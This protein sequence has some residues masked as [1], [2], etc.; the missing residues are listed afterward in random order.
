MLAWPSLGGCDFLEDP[1][2]DA[3]DADTAWLPDPDALIALGPAVRDD[4]DPFSLWSIPGP[5]SLVHDGKRLLIRTRLG[6]RVVRLA[7]SLSLGDG[8]AFAYA[9]PPGRGRSA[10]AARAAAAELTDMLAGV[11]PTTRAAALTRTMVV[12]MRA[13][14]ALDAERAGAS[15]REIGQELF[16][17]A[18]QG[19]DWNDSAERAQVRYLLRQGRSMRDGGYRHLLHQASGTRS[20][21]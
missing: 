9:V 4:G 18:D 6:R 10:K 21:L 19:G 13:L 8:G 12:H 5:K 1:R 20:S 17:S 16:G 15:E 3:R 7:V 2:L 14:Q 11:P